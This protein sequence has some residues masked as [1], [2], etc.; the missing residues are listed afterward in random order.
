MTEKRSW[1]LPTP[2][3]WL[4]GLLEAIQVILAMTLLVGLPVLVM[5]LAGGFG[6]FDPA[7]LSSFAAQIWLII[8]GVP[9]ELSVLLEEGALGAET[10]IP[11]GGWFHLLPMG[12]TLIP[13]FLGWRAGRRLAQGAY[14]G[15]LW[16]GLLTL[17]LGYAAAGAGFSYLAASDGFDVLPV[18][19]AVCAGAV[20][21]LGSLGG[22]YGE[23]R[24]WTRL[25]GID[26]EARVEAFS[27]Q[28]KWAGY[29]AWA[30]LRA[31]V[32]AC[33]AAVGLA[34]V[35]L[36]GQVA[37]HWMDIANV[38]QQLDPGIWGATGLTLLHLGLTPNLIMWTLSYSTGAGFAVGE[39]TTVAPYASELGPVPAVPVLGAL[40]GEPHALGLAVVLL[41]VLAG[42]LAGWWL[43][44]EGENHLDDW[45]ALR[46]SARPLSLTL[47]TLALGVFTGAATAAIALGP[48]WLS[49]I[50]LGMG[51]LVDIGPNA[52]QA[53]AML[54]GWVALG[55]IIGYLIAPAAHQVR[56][57]RRVYEELEQK[58]A[59][60]ETSGEE[61]P[62]AD[63][64]AEQTNENAGRTRASDTGEKRE[65]SGLQVVPDV[66]ASADSEE[67]LAAELPARDATPPKRPFPGAGRKKP[68]KNLPPRSLRR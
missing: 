52:W 40:P 14:S 8:H 4:F 20:L 57:R 54:G 9:V 47:S 23:A 41:P 59:A 15:Q 38:Y 26:L 49:H 3:L 56:R 1:K 67:E 34:A 21:M 64:A 24:S 43:M 46:I 22:S 44:R 18:W 32:V 2:P 28:L 55:T 66:D 7:F 5:G 30:V 51:R 60:E 31:G 37:V 42:V 10:Q 62:P 33:V 45:F 16:Q 19:G 50:S 29:Y 68:G 11:D 36:A 58:Q 6:S 65:D 12:L 25:I 63:E 27:Q 35:L 39:G 17:I 53:A 61:A 13:F 48:L